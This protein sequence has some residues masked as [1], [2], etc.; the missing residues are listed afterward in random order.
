MNNVQWNI[1]KNERLKF[2]R[3]VSFEEV[4]A[5]EFVTTVDHPTRQGQRIL[6]FLKQGYLWAVPYVREGDRIF[7]K[8]LYPCRKYTKLY[9]KGRLGH[10]KSEYT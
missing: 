5:S 2:S 6:L 7:L 10:E 1:L 4:L 8:T 9:R 3:G